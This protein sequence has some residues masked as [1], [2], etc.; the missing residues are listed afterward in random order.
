MP[1]LLEKLK[2]SIQKADKAYGEALKFLRDDLSRRARGGYSL[3]PKF[4]RQKLNF[5]EF[6]ETPIETLAKMG[7]DEIRKQQDELKAAADRISPGRSLAQTLGSLAADYPKPEELVSTASTL[8]AELRKFVEEKDLVT[9]PADAS[10]EVRAL[11]PFSQ[12][13]LFARLDSP[14]PLEKTTASFYTITLPDPSWSA[15]RKEQ[16]RMLLN[17][18]VMPILSIHET[19]VTRSESW[20]SCGFAKTIGKPGAASSP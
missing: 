19:Y 14:G 18:A 1:A 12:G 13:L 3:G 10:P 9:V 15:S 11:K 4:F 16:H 20:R 5:E 6:V 2:T 7:E 8:T 17:R